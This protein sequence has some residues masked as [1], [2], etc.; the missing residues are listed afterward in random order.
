MLIISGFVSWGGG[1]GVVGRWAC[2]PC[3]VSGGARAR[4]SARTSKGRDGCRRQRVIVVHYRSGVYYG[5]QAGH[6]V[7]HCDNGHIL[8]NHPCYI[9]CA[10]SHN[11][12]SSWVQ[13]P[14]L[15]GSLA[16]W[17]AL[18]LVAVPVATLHHSH[19]GLAMAKN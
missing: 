9:G 3:F 10:C 16:V 12:P 14:Q 17:L 7:G 15:H 2:Y 13:N 6:R 11:G 8:I 5:I 4:L 19:M 18:A 1:G